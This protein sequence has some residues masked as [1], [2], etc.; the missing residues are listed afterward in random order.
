[1][2]VLS[3]DRVWTGVTTSEDG[4]VFV[5]FPSA[6][7]PGLQVAEAMPDGRLI[8]Y[9]DAGWNQARDDHD[10]AGAFVCVNALR[11]G[12]NGRLWI[13]DAGAPGIGLPAVAGGARLIAIDLATDTIARSYDLG[14]TRRQTSYLD[15][16]RFND[17][18]AY[19][20]DAGAPGLIVLDLTTGQARRVLDGHPSTIDRR[21]MHADG[22]VLRRQDGSELRVHADQLEVSPDGRYLYFQ[23][24]S[25]PLARIETRWLDDPS[26][27][28][29]TLAERV[30][31]WLDTP[32]TGGTAIDAAGTIYLSDVE[33]RQILTIM[34]DRQVDTL[35][36]DPRLIWGD[37]MWIDSSGNLW[38]PA[39]QLNRT[40]GLAGGAE[41]VDYPVWIYKLKIDASPPANDHT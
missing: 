11:T 9:P 25:G 4:R 10:P 7:G 21:T 29:D 34:P 2:P 39:A 24:A 37:A 15:D 19:L 12:P 31:T 17:Q 3:A 38:I 30:E 41:A 27:P 1:M 13:V 32:T 26:V 35:L 8:P 33:H 22:Q 28:D 36:A 40:P 16:V 20:T 18:T 6:D 5:S 23:P 14:A